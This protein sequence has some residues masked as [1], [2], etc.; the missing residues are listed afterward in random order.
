[1]WTMGHILANSKNCGMQQ[2]VGGG[3]KF[4]FLNRSPSTLV[5]TPL[6]RDLPAK[7]RS[8]VLFFIHACMSSP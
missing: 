8:G 4:V 6:I 5:Q 7:K 2:Q 3:I 1:M